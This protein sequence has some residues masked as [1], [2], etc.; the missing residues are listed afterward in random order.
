MEAIS[1]LVQRFAALFPDGVVMDLA[2]GAGRHTHFLSELRGEGILAVDRNPDVFI[3]AAGA[4]ITP[5]QLD[6]EDEKFVW[7][8]ESSRFA[9]IIVANYLHRPLAAS[10]VSRLKPD[11]VLIIINSA[12]LY[13][14]LFFADGLSLSYRL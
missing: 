9:G 14:K 3:A 5:F 2:C 7:S 8:F 12:F 1:P 6:L 13:L 10:I 4:G 11:G